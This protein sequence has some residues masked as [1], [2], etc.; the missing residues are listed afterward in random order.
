V[1]VIAWKD[2]AAAASQAEINNTAGQY[3]RFRPMVDLFTSPSVVTS[4]ECF[5]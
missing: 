5:G 3:R 2:C 4:R 1:L